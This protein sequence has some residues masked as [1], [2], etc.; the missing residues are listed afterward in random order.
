MSKR[1]ESLTVAITVYNNAASLKESFLSAASQLEDS[2]EIIIVDDGSTDGSGLICEAM[3]RE[4]SNVRVF[5]QENSGVSVARNV[6]ID[7]ARG[8]YIIFI[9]ADDTLHENGLNIY[10]DA[11]SQSSPD[12]IFGD[13][14]F[15]DEGVEKVLHSINGVPGEHGTDAAKQLMSCCLE[16]LG[17]SDSSCARMSGAVWGKAYRTD[18]LNKFGLRFDPSLRRAQDIAFNLQALCKINKILYIQTPTYRHTIFPDSTSHRINIDLL[19]QMERYL[20]SVKKTVTRFSDDN[21]YNDYCFNALNLIIH[22]ATRGGYLE[23]GIQL[24]KAVEMIARRPIFSDAISAARVRSFIR[25]RENIKL[26]LLKI[27]SYRIFS[28]MLLASSR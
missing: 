26:A 14:Q 18:F 27:K 28:R 13:Y 15:V 21:L 19:E 3:Q 10:R 25:V 7:N 20:T 5:H 9:D 8:R 23:D 17:F 24:H 4:H 12:I 22:I 2:D 16:G 11:A 6:A 1:A